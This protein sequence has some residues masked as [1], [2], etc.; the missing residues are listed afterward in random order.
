MQKKQLLESIK[1]LLV[2][3]PHLPDD[4]RDYWLNKIESLSQ[5]N[6]KKL[7]KI[8]KE[9]NE[10]FQKIFFKE[11]IKN[12]SDTDL[13]ETQELLKKISKDIL[14]DQESE[15]RKEDQKHLEKLLEEL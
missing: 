7:Y 4:K 11:I 13:S 5:E 6:L 1:T 14:K 12:S 2:Q 15:E 8:L 9:E 3:I 10:D